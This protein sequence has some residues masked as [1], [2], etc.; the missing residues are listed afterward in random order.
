VIHR[1]IKP[2]NILFEAGHAVVTDFGIARAVSAAGGEK[3]TETGLAVGTPAYMS[4]EQAMGTGEA[5]ARADVYSLACVLYEMLG[6]DTP[7]SGTT[8]Q[9]ILARKVSEPAPPLRTLRD[10]VAGPLEGV[11]LKAL[12][13]SPAD[14]YATATQFAEALQ[15]SSA[16][17]PTSLALQAAAP[18]AV[19]IAGF[20]LLGSLVVLGLVHL[21]VLQLGLPGWVSTGALV[22]LA[23]SLP[24]ATLTGHIERGR[25]I[26]RRAGVTEGA[27][28]GP[29]GWFTWRRAIMSGALAFAGLT[30]V[31]AT[32]MTMRLFGVGPVATLVA[33]GVLGE[34]EPVILA[35]F[36][37]RSGD[38]TL[39]VAVTEAFR[40]D[41]GQSPSVRLTRTADLREELELMQRDPGTPLDMGLA[42]EIAVRR[43]IK[44]VVGGEIN[45]VGGGYIL[46]VRLVAPESGE[47]L[48]AFR[49]TTA[50]EAE[51]IPAIDRLSKRL[52]QRIGESLR[53][54]RATP[55]LSAVTTAS[56]PAL[57]TFAQGGRAWSTGNPA[58]AADFY[59]EAI[60]LDTTFAAAYRQLAIMLANQGRAG[61]EEAVTAMTK[62]FEHRERLSLRERYVIESSYYMNVTIEP[63]RAIDAYSRLLDIDPTNGIAL[64]NTALMYRA[65]R[66]HERAATFGA[67]ILEARPTSALYQSNQIMFLLNADSVDE[68]AVVLGQFAERSP[69]H[70]YV[71]AAVARLATARGDLDRAEASLRKAI[72][73]SGVAP[74]WRTRYSRGL[75]LVLARRGKYAEARRYVRQ[76]MD[77]AERV[78]L[79]AEYLQ[80]VAGQAQLDVV[81]GGD[82]AAAI[83]KLDAA[84]ERYP[85]D[86]MEPPDRPYVDLARGYA[87]AGHAGRAAALLAVHEEEVAEIFRRHSQQA[88]DGVLGLIAL[89]E[90]RPSDAVEA[91]RRP[92][93]ALCL[94]CGL[95]GLGQA[96]D[97]MDNVDSA[98]A[99]YERYVEKSQIHV[100]QTQ[101]WAELSP[102][103]D[104]PPTCRRIGE[105]YQQRGNDE[106]AVYYYNLFVELW[107]DADPELQ[108]QVDEVRDRLVR[109]AG[110]PRGGR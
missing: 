48:A 97:M 30:L 62:A 46:S 5:D 74:E 22:L 31:T 59:R 12:A 75:V 83:E 91:F 96:Y 105:L 58:L 10:T 34:R 100:F 38:S 80:S 18:T 84:L 2:E 3:L 88:R 52:R 86:S 70:P 102:W 79:L 43:G 73:D 55:A 17:H 44:A 36:T 87:R 27:H 16:A 65:L 51:V 37:D 41:L 107:Q 66:D 101:P 47:D 76:L 14:R 63:R 20:Y 39:A 53:T 94:L 72:D 7:F 24:L 9:A 28:A 67:R 21:L 57:R 42:R 92:N 110:E 25:A 15:R 8:P 1:D 61:S 23:I 85:L 40:V 54:V 108:P 71:V 98:I 95:P 90:G 33:A 104:L 99:V 69:D 77:D 29:S 13:R 64:T 19:R 4:P 26:A 68:A 50:S 35:E 82:P 6:G 32:Y 56:L 103:I 78:D 81:L 106:K 11:V 109:L 60:A 93:V 49:E 45:A 89:A